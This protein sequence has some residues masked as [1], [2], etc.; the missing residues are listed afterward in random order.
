[1]STLR[2]A[3]ARRRSCLGAPLAVAAATAL[4]VGCGTGGGGEPTSRASYTLHFP[5]TEAAVVTDLI[6]VQVFDAKG[7]PALCQS[8]VHQ[9]VSQQTLP[10]PILDV[11]PVRLCD[12]LANGGA[13]PLAFPYGERAVLVV[14]TRGDADFLVGCTQVTAT[15]AQFDV[16]IALSLVA[17]DVLPPSTT[18]TTLEDHCG[19]KC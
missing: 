7:E 12:L 19:G 1:M 15:G 14:G 4:F 6:K 16:P 5:S 8:L 11:T 10:A 2:F 13:Y 17:G 3:V 9:R 18:C